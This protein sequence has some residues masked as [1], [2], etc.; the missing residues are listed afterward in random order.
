M[1]TLKDKAVNGLKWSIVDNLVNSGITFLVGLVLARLLSP[2]EFG[3]LGI[4][5]IFI[6]I[7]NTIVDGGFVTALIRKPNSTE[8]DY[9]T[10]FYSNLAISLFLMLLLCLSSNWIAVFFEQP[11]LAKI[12]PWMSLLLL[13]NAFAIIQRTLLIKKIDFKTQAKISLISSLGSGVIG[14]GMAL[15]GYGVWSLVAQQLSRQLLLTIFLWFFSAWRPRWQFSKGSFKDLFGFGSKV[16]IANLINSIY[17][18][19]FLAVVGKMYSAKDLGQY[20]RAEQFNLIFTNNLTMVLQKVTM[21]T[22][23]Q[24]QTDEARFSYAF[25]KIVNYSA[26]I[27]FALVLGLAAV[28]KPLLMILIGEQWMPAVKYLQI[29]SLYGAIYPL[30][31]LNVNIL[32]VVKRSDLLLRLEIIKKTLFI[33]VIVTGFFF[34]LEYMIWAAVIYYYIEFVLNSWYSERYVNYGTWKQ[35][36]NMLPIFVFS[37]GISALVWLLTLTLLPYWLM[38]CLQIIGAI[39]LYYVGYELWGQEDYKELKLLIIEQLK[40]FIH[41]SK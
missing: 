34:E 18:D 6:N 36:K 30:Q 13:I 7:S 16:L 25:R 3:I 4:I 32:N 8:D 20:N 1:S 2:V 40:L 28:A 26:I 23:S 29:M 21:P 15:T 24:V 38:L 27:T 10:V 41:R 5:T 33:A 12:M 39:L 31:V 37:L 9:N 35:V 22:F 19:M 14:I 17:K 11:I